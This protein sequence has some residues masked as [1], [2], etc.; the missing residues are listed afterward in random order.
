MILRLFLLTLTLLSIHTSL[1][2]QINYDEYLP[3]KSSGEIP[4]SLREHCKFMLFDNTQT[5]YLSTGK[6]TEDE[7]RSVYNSL[8]STGK[9]VFGEDT[10]FYCEQLLNN[11][12]ASDPEIRQPVEIYLFKSSHPCALND[13]KSIIYI[14]TA[15]V[16]HLDKADQ[17][18]FLIAQQL[19]HLKNKSQPEFMKLNRTSDYMERLK[20]VGTYAVETNS[21]ADTYALER[22]A[23]L[24]LNP[25][26]AL[27]VLDILGAEDRSVE[28]VEIPANY[29]SSELL[30][31]PQALFDNS[32]YRFEKIVPSAEQLAFADRRKALEKSELLKVTPANTD[33]MI[34]SFPQIRNLCVF[35]Y[36][37]DLILENDPEKALYQILVMEQQPFST[38]YLERL[39]VHAWIT[40]VRKSA[41]P[42]LGKTTKKRMIQNNLSGK[43]YIALR[44]L[45]I[46]ATET[47]A[48]RTVTDLMKYSK[49]PELPMLRDYLID[50]IREIG[51]F[52]I[53]SFHASTFPE[54]SK[55]TSGAPSSFYLYGISDLI[56]DSSFVQRITGIDSKPLASDFKSLLAVDPLA[57]SFHKKQFK[58]EKTAGK[59]ALLE[60]TISDRAK[61]SGLNVQF[62]KADTTAPSRWV[63]LYNLRSSYNRLHLQLSNQTQYKTAVFPLV[64]TSIHSLT[65]NYQ[66][67][68]IG[69][70]HFENQYNI[71]PKGYHLTGLLLIPLPFVGT[72]LFLGGNHC[73]YI[74][75][76]IDSKTGK[77]NYF[78]NSKYRDPMTKFFIQNK[79][80]S[81]F[82][83]I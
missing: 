36:I 53:S 9:I 83:R 76:V 42:L 74:S 66:T 79:V 20:M 26:S 45:N 57:Y 43:F 23:S 24:K 18:Y 10:H 41:Y 19:F 68:A 17:L 40:F 14:S 55:N 44:R 35:Q 77:L 8:A 61:E 49:D 63:D 59:T 75:F 37:E 72:D 29:L 22:I 27:E 7:I 13:G 71:N 32:A 51:T 78:E 80:Q 1:S 73:Q 15:L 34:S 39:K 5:P 38:Q 4:L 67:D 11:L 65:K 82:N 16:A 46:H 30:Q 28:E 21:K 48:L 64:L 52:P 31:F 6:T 50:L 3:L 47:I 33:L 12:I 58:A 62:L 2:A 81:S 60:N 25:L 56:T 70:F 69:V 54:A